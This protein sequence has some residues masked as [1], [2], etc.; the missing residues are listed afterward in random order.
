MLFLIVLRAKPVLRVLGW[1]AASA[2]KGTTTP[3]GSAFHPQNLHGARGETDTWTL[4]FDTCACMST[5]TY[6]HTHMHAHTPAHTHP[7]TYSHTHAHAQAHIHTC[8]H[9]IHHE[10]VLTCV[11]THMYTP[12]TVKVKVHWIKMRP[13]ITIRRLKVISDR[14]PFV[15]E[16]GPGLRNPRKT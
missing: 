14:F 8:A 2:G 7:H 4:S 11:D 3:D 13:S 5:H 16:I 9:T 6:A 1:G 12:Y 10:G 15:N